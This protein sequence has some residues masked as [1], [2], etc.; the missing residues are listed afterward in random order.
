[1]RISLRDGKRLAWG[2]PAPISYSFAIT[3]GNLEAHL[4][5]EEGAAPTHPQ[6][7]CARD[8]RKPIC[9]KIRVPSSDSSSAICQVAGCPPP[10]YGC[11]GPRGEQLGGW[12][13]PMSRPAPGLCLGSCTSQFLRDS[14]GLPLF[15]L[16]HQLALGHQ[17]PTQTFYLWRLPS[18][19]THPYPTIHC[20]EEHGG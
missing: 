17:E 16:P 1:M 4:C 3:R 19:G 20:S 15:C 14:K 11:Q 9:P 13:D 7:S 18:P 6:A 2:L 12:A 8:R 5:C 10:G